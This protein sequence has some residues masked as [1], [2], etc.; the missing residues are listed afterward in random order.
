MW[1]SSSEIDSPKL[2]RSLSAAKNSFNKVKKDFE[3]FSGINAT[4]AQRSIVATDTFEL[5]VVDISMADVV[6]VLDTSDLDL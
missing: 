2:Y 1:K 4:F 6:D 3:F 5:M